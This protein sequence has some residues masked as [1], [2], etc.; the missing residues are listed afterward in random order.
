MAVSISSVEVRQND[1]VQISGTDAFRLC[2]PTERGG[3]TADGFPPSP[4]KGIPVQ[5]T[6]DGVSVLLASV[7]ADQEG[8]LDAAV[9]VPATASPGPAAIVVGL[10]YPNI[11][12]LELMVLDD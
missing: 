4:L 11:V 8:R 7:D 5:W 10:E 12:A 3:A 2:S 1:Q 9:V 6:Q